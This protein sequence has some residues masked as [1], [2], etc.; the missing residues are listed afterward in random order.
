MFLGITISLSSFKPFDLKPSISLNE[1]K[2]FEGANYDSK[3][4]N[5]CS[6]LLGDLVWRLF[7]QSSFDQILFSAF[8]R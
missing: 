5:N 8:R 6:L 3:K 2:T 1:M 7:C 4:S